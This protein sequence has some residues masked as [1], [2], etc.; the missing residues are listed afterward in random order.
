MVVGRGDL[1]G[2][3]VSAADKIQPNEKQVERWTC[4]DASEDLAPQ[5]RP[6]RTATGQKTIRSKEVRTGGA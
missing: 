6:K 3:F 2:Q 5:K 4:N 1:W